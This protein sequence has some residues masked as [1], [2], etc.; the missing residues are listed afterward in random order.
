M[1]IIQIIVYIGI[2]IW[3]LSPDPM[4]I[5]LTTKQGR[6]VLLKGAGVVASGHLLSM[7]CQ[8]V[9]MILLNSL[10]IPL[11]I[12]FFLYSAVFV[13]FWLLEAELFHRIHYKFSIKK[14]LLKKKS[15][16]KWSA[17][18]GVATIA[19]YSYNRISG[20][21]VTYAL[22]ELEPG[23]VKLFMRLCS[24]LLQLR[25]PDL[26]LA[27]CYFVLYH[28]TMKIIIQTAEWG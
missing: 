23:I 20:L 22:A 15:V 1:A 26:F 28:R 9:M 18:T 5:L 14:A 24:I 2:F 17:I 4:K 11:I 7:T 12:I 25:L 21:A 3:M 16:V 10:R 13:G 19:F 8:M 27:L 6:L